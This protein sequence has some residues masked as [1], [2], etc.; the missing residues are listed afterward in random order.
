[1]SSALVRRTQS[2]RVDFAFVLY[3]GHGTTY[4]LAVAWPMPGKLLWSVTL[5]DSRDRDEPAR[6]RESATGRASFEVKDG[7]AGDSL[8][9][10]LGPLVHNGARRH[11]I[12]TLSGRGWYTHCRIY[13]PKSSRSVAGGADATIAVR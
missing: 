11:S 10:Y 4:K 8:H 9:P 7:V 5:C 6:D 12:K 13:V 1:M 2:R 3:H